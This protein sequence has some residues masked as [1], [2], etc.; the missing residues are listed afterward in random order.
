MDSLF[1]TISR[2]RASSACWSAAR[3][4]ILIL[5][6]SS[7]LVSIFRNNP[8]RW[9]A[10]LYKIAAFAGLWVPTRKDDSESYSTRRQNLPSLRQTLQV[11]EDQLQN[12]AAQARPHRGLSGGKN[13]P[14]GVRV[15]HDARCCT[16]PGVRP[17]IY[18]GSVY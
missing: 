6:M 11:E 1:A 13:Q 3:N 9:T 12:S 18:A 4:A 15:I 10:V 2:T 5:F 14:H 7:R 8:C 17:E 16:R